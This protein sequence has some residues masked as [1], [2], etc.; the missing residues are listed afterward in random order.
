M[1]CGTLVIVAFLFALA[2]SIVPGKS[3]STAPDD[4]AAKKVKKKPE[5]AKSS[6]KAPS[7]PNVVTS[8]PLGE[9]GPGMVYNASGIISIGE[10][11][12][13]FCD[14]R[15][16]RELLEL[17]L[18][19]QG[20]KIGSIIRRPLTGVAPSAVRDLEGMTI[21]ER[22]GDRF[23]VATS[24][25]NR[26]NPS[27]GKQKVEQYAGGL[28][29]IRPGTEKTLK[30]EN[31]AGF[32]EWL[33]SKYP[34][35]KASAHLVPD[36]GG[37]NIEGLTWDPNR[38]ALLFGVRTPLVNG[39]P[40]ILPV[41]LKGESSEWRLEDFE[42][43]P[44][45]ALQVPSPGD[46]GIRALAYAPKIKAFVLSLGKATSD[47]KVPFSIYVWDGQDAGAVRKLEH[48]H[49]ARGMKVEGLAGAM[50]GGK[51]ALLVLDD[52]G[53]YQVISEDDP[54]LR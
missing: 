3:Q 5:A 52:A 26:L 34:E 30:A 32:R 8:L 43:L 21:V 51:S 7:D 28:L 15:N 1:K 39:K 40:I 27:K 45:I 20:K 19:D 35:L 46:T 24:S 4:K 22:N 53:G 23:A 14:N 13:L 37:L 47:L 12:F 49:F 44:A 17:R 25:F 54:R 10:G 2:T 9:S 48:L 18:D 38:G 6:E 29:R 42:P 31:I 16:P 50:V 11:R 36:E 41:R 33:V